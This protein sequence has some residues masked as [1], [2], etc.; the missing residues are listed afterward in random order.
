MAAIVIRWQC[1]RCGDVA[2]TSDITF[3]V[4]CPCLKLSVHYTHFAYMQRIIPIGRYQ[5]I[6]VPWQPS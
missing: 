3:N 5:L 4:L 1:P 6:I 2:T